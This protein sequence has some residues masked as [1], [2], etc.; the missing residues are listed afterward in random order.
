MILSTYSLIAISAVA[1][2]SISVSFGIK[3]KDRR[4]D[5]CRIEQC[6]KRPQRPNYE[7][8]R[9]YH[10]N[11]HSY[12]SIS[13][14]F[15]FQIYNYERDY[16]RPIIIQQPVYREPVY[17]EPIVIQPVINQPTTQD[18]FLTFVNKQNY[19]FKCNYKNRII[20]L[21]PD[22]L[23]IVAENAFFYSQEQYKYLQNLKTNQKLKL[24][25]LQKQ[26]QVSIQGVE[27]IP[28][29][30]NSALSSITD[31]VYEQEGSFSATL[32]RK[33][34][35]YIVVKLSDESEVTLF[36]NQLSSELQSLLDTCANNEKL[37]LV[38][39]LKN[40]RYYLIDAKTTF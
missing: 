22:W 32:L 8:S 15:P 38:W 19:C 6:N 2:S 36:F 25:L 33:T 21:Y 23:G 7:R 37:K 4:P 29:T 28:P 14:G 5:S 35:K 39:G 13:A 27:V 30:E 24:T 18:V 9:Y 31:E 40:H 34:S 26:N 12:W 11:H 20:Y 16:C 1:G 10:S 17:Q 3:D